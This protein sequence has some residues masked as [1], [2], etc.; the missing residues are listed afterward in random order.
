[1]ALKFDDYIFYHIPKTGGNYIRLV[2]QRITT[3]I[4]EIT[5]PH[6]SPLK[7]GKKRHD[8]EKS[9]CVVRH[10]LTWYESFFRYR[11]KTGWR[12]GQGTRIYND[13]PHPIDAH[14]HSDTFRAFISKMLVYYPN[15]WVTSLY[16]RFI[17]FCK[18]TL[19]QENLTPELK[20]LLTMFGYKKF[21]KVINKKT[22]VTQGSI[23]T[24]LPKDLRNKI[25]KAE[26]E[27][28]KY[29]GY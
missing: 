6:A 11:I 16:L 9:F 2:L 7:V 17:P 15:G 13:G 21:P 26:S 22:N 19:R 24:K 8:P 5:H 18:Y 14:C 29:L 25:L 4:E 1:M 20:E 12:L 10:P 3:D 23:E 28:I 27:I